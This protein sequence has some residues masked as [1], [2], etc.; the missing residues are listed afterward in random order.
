MS[1]PSTLTQPLHDGWNFFEPSGQSWRAA[2][3]PGCIHQDLLRHRLIPDPFYGKNELELGWIGDRDWQYRL[4][5]EVDRELLE[6][7]VVELIF[8]G[9]D[10]VARV[11]LN[12]ELILESDNMFHEHRIPVKD[13]LR[14]GENKL[15]ISFGS[16]SRY[17][18]THRPDFKAP[19][20]FNDRTGECVR[21]RKEG[22]QFG[23][24][25]GPRLVT[26]GI[27]RQVRIEGRSGNRITSVHVRQRHFAD[28]VEVEIKPELAR[29]DSAAEFLATLSLDGKVVASEAGSHPSLV[30][31]DPQ[32]WWPAGQGS[33]PLYDL[34][35]NLLD[36]EK[37]LDSWT[38]RVGLRA[39]E[40]DREADDYT[41]T[42]AQGLPMNRFGFRVNGRLIFSKGANWIP[43][44]SFVHGLG[45]EN[46]KPLLESAAL[47]HMNMVRAWGGGIYEHEGFYDLCDEL[48]LLVWQDFMFAC[49]LY[50]SDEA[51]LT[52]VRREAE[53]NVRRIRHHASLAL[54]CGNNEIAMLNR[55]ALMPGAG[56]V[57]GY[58]QLFHNL[59]PEVLRS[60]D[61]VTP[62]IPSSP[63]CMLPERPDTLAPSQDDHDWNVWHA[64]KPVEHYESTRHRFASEFGMQSYPSLELA[65]TFC[66][67]DELN[68]F[69]PVFDNHQK[70]GGGN[71]I[72]FDYVSRL[73][74]FPKDYRAA[75]YLSQLNQ[76]WCMK[77]AVEHWRRI[78]PL[79]LGALYWQLN[80]CWPVASWSSLEFGGK[81]KALH[82]EARR[83][84][85][86]HLVSIRHLGAEN[87]VV[88]NFAVSTT[89]PVE[90]HAVQDTP[91]TQSCTLKRQICHLDGEILDT[92][93][94]EWKLDP[95]R[96]HLLETVDFSVLVTKH[97]RENVY[98][99]A[100]LFGDDGELKAWNFSFFTAPR[101][102]ALR[103]SPIR[104]E[105]QVAG[106]D[107]YSLT[108]ESD[109]FHH[110]V[111]LE[112]E[113]L[114]PRWSDNFFHLP[115][116]E[117]KVVTVKF[118]AE[119]MPE[120]PLKIVPY[121][122]V[123]SFS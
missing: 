116:G 47:A 17:V 3:V 72:I 66:P 30:V 95:Q 80:D 70:N 118:P 78:S 9:L 15:E 75:A 88:G 89:G 40:L 79:C 117:K 1:I 92:V 2:V 69:S 106:E 60:L 100:D 76:A 59:L 35:V 22:C 20:N 55:D 105:S 23:W 44:H 87:K 26:A 98:L 93:E 21:I 5:F 28:R 122:L 119:L 41:L 110:S 56:F 114:N 104:I 86:P 65:R 112:I 7:R 62:Y 54:W 51:F 45:R 50:P 84:F 73:F 109:T 74:R 102:L 18:V 37:V 108:L 53:D 33:Q 67:P 82:H 120:S 31:S 14:A 101:S 27:W 4:A 63:D 81:W 19:T 83:F 16:A 96:G 25:W 13:L 71:Q 48:G 29:A 10:T 42:N 85:A 8:E 97:G 113:G 121:S 24:D 36:G 64:R 32:L 58:V 103:R 11:L 91:F 123:D 43:A 52:S 34:Q 12:G 107:T 49:D 57:E 111:C 115:A 90:I 99:R 46:Y 68:I 77:V 61:P 6:Q 38:R 94:S 39:I